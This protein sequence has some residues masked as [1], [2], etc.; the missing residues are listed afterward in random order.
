MAT[1]SSTSGSTG[2]I[3]DALMSAVN[4]R[5]TTTNS[6]DASK[7]QFLKLLTTQL[8]NQDPSNPMDNASMTSQMAMLNQVDS[9]N[10]M[11][12]TMSKMLDAFTNNS[13][14]NAIGMIGKVVQVPGNNTV[15]YQGRADAGFT[16]DS[17]AD[18]VNINIYDSNGALVQT[19]GLGKQDAGQHSFTW[20]GS[21]K[22]AVKDADGNY[23]KAT[24][25][26][27]TFKVVATQGSTNE[28]VNATALQY[29]QVTSVMKDATTSTTKLQVGT[30]GQYAMT[31]V[32]NIL[33]PTSSASSSSSSSSESSSGSSSG[34]SNQSSSS[35]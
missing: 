8:T 19:V 31:D 25:G 32:Y 35:N 18:S 13:T 14:V 2:T 1:T 5:K 10:Q 23:I 17:A 6:T 29:G 26:A 4:T 24:D 20:D 7:Q 11:N 21:K 15:L 12:A 27:Y 16:L 33:A 30:Y 3:S 28:K 22:D 34:S 9:L